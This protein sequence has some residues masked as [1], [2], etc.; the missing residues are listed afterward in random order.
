MVLAGRHRAADHAPVLITANPLNPHRYVVV[1]SGHT[2]GA[3]EFAR[4]NALLFP[5]LGDYAVIRVEGENDE[6]KLSGFFDESWKAR[7]N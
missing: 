1:N 3:K 4:T 2:F 6:V 5:H 7:A